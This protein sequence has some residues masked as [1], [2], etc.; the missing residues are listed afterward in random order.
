M[1]ASKQMIDSTIQVAARA[2]SVLQKYEPI[3][4]LQAELNK[5]ID[6]FNDEYLNL[7]VIG[8]FSS[9]KSTFL[10]ALLRQNLLAVD[11]LATTA[12]ITRITWKS[13]VIDVGINV[14]DSSGT[15]W[16][17]SG[18]GKRAFEKAYKIKL[19]KETGALIDALTTDNSLYDTVKEVSLSFPPVTGRERICLV[20]TPGTNAGQ[21]GTEHHRE[22]TAS[23]LKN[24][25]DA[26]IILFST[27]QIVTNSFVEYIEENA[28]HL[29]NNS[30]II[31]TKCDN[32]NNEKDSKAIPMMVKSAVE[33]LTGTEPVVYMISAAKALE[34]MLGDSQDDSAKKWHDSFE[35]DILEI[36]NGLEERRNAI[37][38]QRLTI[39]LKTLSE[40]L[41]NK[42]MTFQNAVNER[43]NTL[44]KNSPKE[45]RDALQ[46]IVDQYSEKINARNETYVK[47][48]I[49]EIDSQTNDTFNLISDKVYRCLTMI[50]VK[51]YIKSSA[52]RQI[53][54]LNSNIKKLYKKF[55]PDYEDL[56]LECSNKIYDCCLEYAGRLGFSRWKNGPKRSR[57]KAA[58]TV[59]ISFDISVSNYYSIPE[60]TYN[61]FGDLL[62]AVGNALLFNFLDASDHF[63]NMVDNVK[64]GITSV[65]IPLSEKK[66]H[67]IGELREIASEQNSIIS[68]SVSKLVESKASPSVAYI[69]NLPTIALQKYCREFEKVET[70]FNYELADLKS[71]SDELNELLLLLCNATKELA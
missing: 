10:N 26:A 43:I 59:N 15:V 14:T 1:A 32:V 33:Q 37:I 41:T 48:L 12:C 65:K 22:I 57:I 36:F 51:N 56:C 6:R 9:G 40:K 71:K 8:E 49:S 3:D 31:I 63:H 28:S 18:R 64:S 29:L 7:A 21:V 44:S 62:N 24:H 69:N 58:D 45:F 35:H 70:K 23:F 13:S 53:S 52:P 55:K 27:N 34:Y 30:I 46:R 2:I 47:D 38:N 42:L 4:E 66:Q 11:I 61:L 5:I 17:I 68:D 50:A 20:D 25:A 67:I 60:I 39:L 16:D 54:H 19:P